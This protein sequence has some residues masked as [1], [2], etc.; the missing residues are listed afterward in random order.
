[1]S[2]LAKNT[3]RSGVKVAAIAT[4]TIVGMIVLIPVVPVG[5]VAL[6]GAKAWRKLSRRSRTSEKAVDVARMLAAAPVYLLL[7]NVDL[8]IST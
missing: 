8:S 1:M 6:A 5:C 3:D 7:R 2:S 4:G